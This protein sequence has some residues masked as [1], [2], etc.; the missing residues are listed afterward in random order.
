MSRAVSN[1]LGEQQAHAEQPLSQREVICSV[2]AAGFGVQSQDNKVRD[3]NRGKPQQFILAGLLFTA[4]FTA[5]LVV[6]IIFIV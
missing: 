2:I 1:K 6:L 4:A 5:G 3:F